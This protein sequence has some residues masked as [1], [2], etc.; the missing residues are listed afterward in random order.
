M[1]SPGLRTAGSSPV[2]A[3]TASFDCG[4]RT[5]QSSSGLCRANIET[6]RSESLS[7]RTASG[8]SLPANQ[9]WFVS[10]K[11]P[12]DA[13]CSFS[14][15]ER[16]FGAA[17]SPDGLFFASAGSDRTLRLW[18]AETYEPALSLLQPQRDGGNSHAVAF[19]KDGTKVAA[20][21][22]GNILIWSLTDGGPPVTIE[23]CHRREIY[24]LIFLP[25]GDL[26]SGGEG[27]NLLIMHDD[28]R[29]VRQSA[30][31]LR[32]W[33]TETGGL[34]R[35]FPIGD[36]WGNQTACSV[37]ADGRV[38]V[39]VFRTCLA[40]YDA[41]SGRQQRVIEDYLNLFGTR[42]H[43]ISVSPDGSRV[44]AIGGDHVVR[45]W[46]TGT[47]EPLHRFEDSHDERV[48]QV[49]VSPDS[50]LYA[51]ASYDG[52]FSLWK[53]EDGSHVWRRK[54]GDKDDA[55]GRAIAF[56]PDGS[57]VAGG[58]WTTDLF[59]PGFKGHLNVW[60]ARTGDVL[61]SKE[62]ED[63]VMSLTFARD[64]KKIA[65]GIGLTNFGFEGGQKQVQAAIAVDAKDGKELARTEAP[66]ARLI[67]MRFAPDGQSLLMADEQ[68]ALHHWRIGEKKDPEAV[69]LTG[70]ERRSLRYVAFTR[71]ASTMA[72]SDLFGDQVILR[73]TTDGSAIRTMKIPN[74]KGSVLNFSKDGL[75]LATA[76]IALT[77]T[78]TRKYDSAL[79]LWSVSTGQKLF[80][81]VIADLNPNCLALTPDGTRLLAGGDD[82][83]TL[84][85]DV[86]AVL[87]RA[88]EGGRQE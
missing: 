42:T 57:M 10:S 56:S 40:V 86:S 38:L 28:N 2:V 52:T 74:S 65:V 6:V 88:T 82:G 64:S 15:V 54:L 68:M 37:S 5:Q 55:G 33:N 35:E 30:S 85:L 59:K 16:T 75:I 80:E 44:A 22:K 58:G 39:A 34:K 45:I 49:A 11:W 31:F 17:W 62:F 13:N 1:E 70:H 81:R 71:D 14:S 27:R 47:G 63:R 20:G 51:T 46:D 67:R 29:Q 36:K 60:D 78:G 77:S 4:T 50:S 83:S 18:N 23:K 32:V 24:S 9:A 43:G 69:V 8:L 48:E 84:V 41:G 53:A 3:G 7:L 87:N 73:K 26:V 79:R 61:V 66:R 21:F 19:S 12:A 25:N 76:S 72:T